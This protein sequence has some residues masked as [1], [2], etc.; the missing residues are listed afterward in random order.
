MTAGRA[1]ATALTTPSGPVHLNFPF[2]EP[3]VPAPLTDPW[4][5]GRADNQRYV[6]VDQGVGTPDAAK[7]EKLAAEL[8]ASERGLLVCGPQQDP[9]LPSALVRLAEKL[10]YPIIADPLSGLRSGRHDKTWVLD[11]YDAFLRDESIQHDYVPDVIVRFGAMPV[12][13]AFL[14]YVKKHP[15]C[16]QIVVDRGGWREPTQLA[17]DRIDA[18][19]VAFCEAL[20]T[21]PGLDGKKDL[22]SNQHPADVQQNE[23]RWEKAWLHLNRVTEQQVI[24]REK[25]ETLSEGRVFRELSNDCLPPGTVLFV[26]NSMPVRD[27]DTFFMNN[28]QDMCTMANRGANGIDG[29]TSTALGAS[30]TGASLVL[31]VGDLSF[32]H[33]LNGLLAAKWYHLNVTIVLIN[34]NGG[35]IFSFLPQADQSANFEPLFGTPTDLDFRKAVEMYGGSFHVAADWPDFRSQVQQGAAVDGLNVIEVQT[36]REQNSRDHRMLWQRVSEAIHGLEAL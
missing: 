24:A 22:R 19:P 13:K 30:S 11:G 18:D 15:Q 25:R 31:V 20:L 2:R 34:N 32:Y 16:R 12:S 35:G 10:H 5:G 1:A 23:R 6:D 7:T 14:L 8:M 27:L 3:L 17:S 28:E 36:T 9:E 21:N 29:V 4:P 26:G 33:D